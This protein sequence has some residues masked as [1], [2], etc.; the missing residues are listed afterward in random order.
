MKTKATK[1]PIRS[2]VAK[3][4]QNIWT[5]KK[6]TWKQANLIASIYSPKK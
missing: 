3:L 2:H 4:V 6:F 1:K 5:E